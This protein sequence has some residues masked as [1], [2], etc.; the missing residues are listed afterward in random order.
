MDVRALVYRGADQPDMNVINPESDVWQHIKVG[1]LF[2][3]FLGLSLDPP[4]VFGHELADPVLFAQ[5]RRAAHCDCRSPWVDT[6][7]LDVGPVEAF[8]GRQ[9]QAFVVKSGMVW[10]HHVLITA[11]EVSKSYQI[12]LYSRD[13]ELSNQN[14]LHR[15]IISC[16]VVIL[17]LVDNSLLVYTADN[18]LYHY[19]IVP[20]SDTIKLHLC[21][22]ITFTGII[23]APSAGRMLSWMILSSQKCKSSIPFALDIF[24]PC[25]AELGDPVDDLAVATV[26]MVASSFFCDREVKY[27]MQIFADRIEFCWI[28]LRGINA[29]E[30]SLWAYDGQGIRVWLNAL[31]IE[32]P[33]SDDEPQDTE[34]EREYSS[35]FLST[36]CLNG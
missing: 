20:T 9:E 32:A 11:V 10:F 12:R 18:T 23:A 8:C 13:M 21:G 16:P 6:L 30:N 26:L 1:P 35:Q 3:Q 19:L 2:L 17:S 15:E 29:L 14:V 36:I 27:N 7:Q 5:Q 33:R 4:N 25:P 31:A 24:I 34:G 22:S 28:H